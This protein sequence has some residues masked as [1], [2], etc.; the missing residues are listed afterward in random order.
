MG[1]HRDT[2][3]EFDFDSGR[4]LA[5]RLDRIPGRSLSYLFVV[6]IGFGMVSVLY[7]LFDVNVS[8]IQACV[9][10][11]SGCAPPTAFGVIDL[12]I[13]FSLIGCGLGALGVTP[14]L[15]RFGSSAVLLLTMTV[16][17]LGSA[18]S[19]LSGDLTNFSASRLITGLGI[20]ADLA[21]IS[22]YV[23][24]VA[25]RP[26]RSRFIAILFL[27]AAAG[28]TLAVWLGLGLTTAPARWPDGMSFPLASDPVG[29][30][31]RWMYLIGAAT[32][33]VS[34]LL[35]IALPESPRWL[36]ANGQG[37]QAQAVIEAMEVR[38][39][40]R[41]PLPELKDDVPAPVP[42]LHVTYRGLPGQRI[43][44][45]RCLVLG[46]AWVAA[47]VTLYSFAGGFTS[48]LASF[49]FSPLAAGVVSAVGLIG[50]LASTLVA[51][52][53]SQRLRRSH[54][55]PVG[56]AVAVVGA[57]VVTLGG[58]G[59]A[60]VLV[61]AMILFFGQN[62]WMAPRYALTVGSLPARLRATGCPVTDSIGHV[63]GGI[64]V[65]VVAGLV[66]GLTP[67]AALLILLG[68]L[69][70]AATVNQFAVRTRN[71]QL[72]NVSR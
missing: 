72:G 33:L 38:A 11:G 28:A 35:R 43:S 4:E 62:V 1:Q 36:L 2:S 15:D 13:M 24:E 64:G 26:A 22:T 5:A 25:P 32:A 60:V 56:S 41:G 19:A 20:G 10:I 37:D 71:R 54:W 18:Y 51:V 61:D 52:G 16:I 67:L 23:H 58:P 69:V 46:T 40:R 29:S 6:V 68:F 55:L 31:W 48:V 21:V 63:G 7:D 34:V 47:F 50:F 12:P 45:R 42:G 30:S 17:G 27:P 65:F 57:V 49:G 53:C 70:L 59:A 39:R 66:G 8:L 14:L 9:S 44:L 3:A